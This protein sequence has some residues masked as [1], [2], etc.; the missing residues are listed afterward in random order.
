MVQETKAPE[1][2]VTP[3]VAAS[4]LAAVDGVVIFTPLVGLAGAIAAPLIVQLVKS[5]RSHSESAPPG[6]QAE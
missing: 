4:A 1:P 2:T 6:A 5:V 3:S